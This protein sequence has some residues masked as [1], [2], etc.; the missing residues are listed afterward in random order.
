MLDI[1]TTL[2]E[3]HL[4]NTCIHVYAYDS[5]SA[6]NP[7]GSCI[8]RNIDIG[9]YHAGSRTLLPILVDIVEG[10]VELCKS[11]ASLMDSSISR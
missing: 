8:G 2:V 5:T 4:G 1:G 3:D 10:G 7:S 9:E 6:F 11:L